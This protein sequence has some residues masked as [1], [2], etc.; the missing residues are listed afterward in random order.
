MDAYTSSA[1]AY[2]LIMSF[3]DPADMSGKK[4]FCMLRRAL[5]DGTLSKINHVHGADNPADALTKP[6][7]S[8][9]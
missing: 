6:T 4:K 7:L 3:K 2:D 9:P 5:L 8:R 1:P